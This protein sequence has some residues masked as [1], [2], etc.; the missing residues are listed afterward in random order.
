MGFRISHKLLLLGL[1]S[2]LITAVVLVAVGAWQS[3]R[4]ADSTEKEVLRQNQAALGQS[5]SDVS[6]LV[7]TVGD[8]VQEG[9]DKSMSSASA[10]LSQSGGMRTASGRVSWTATNQVTQEATKV[11]L[12]RIEIGGDWLG[13]NTDLKKATTFVDDAKELSGADVTVFQRMNTAGDLLRV[14]TTVKSAK[15]TRAIGTYIPASADGKANAVAAAILA[16]KTYRGVAVVVGTPYITVYEP[17]KNS[18]GAVIGALFVGVPQADALSTLTTAISETKIQTNG[19]VAVFSTATA[20]RGRIVASNLAD[21]VGQTALDATDADG[22]RY[23]EEIVTKA[24]EL[25]DGSTWQS[26]YQLAGAAGAPAGD[27]TTSVA[28]YAPYQWAVTV[29]GYDADA[30]TAVTVVRDG[31]STMLQ[32]FMI[33]GLLL[34]VAGA[35]LAYL[36]ASRISR[37]MA[38]LTGA[39]QRLANHDLTVRVDDKG[40]DEIGEAG[41]ALNTAVAEL[42]SVMQEVTTA[43]D[44]VAGTAQRVTTTGGEMSAAADTAADRAGA[45]STSAETVSHVV[46]TVAAGAEEMGASISEIS[47]NAQEAAQAGRD[48][49]GLT[50]AAAGVIAELRASTAKITDVVQL[51]ATI[52]EQT[53]LLALNATIEAA[54]AGETGKGFAVVAGEVKELAQETARATEDVTARVAAIN[55]D[56]ARAVQAIDA[57][58][59]RIGQV[60]DYQTA[61][62]AAVEEQAATT[63]EM[64]RNISEAAGGSRDIADGIGTVSGAVQ[65]TRESVATSH[66]AADEL[67]ATAHRLTDLVGRFTVR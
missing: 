56:T 55:A 13:Q 51:I 11:T 50:A 12:P 65:S 22:T 62:A 32:W 6:A 67:T 18:S 30:A 48:G 61:I 4:F 41:I 33:A 47:H 40:S 46:Q 1:G 3:S 14:G 44:E 15:G 7:K 59:E 58:T 52:A 16:G 9:V 24:P 10:F 49:V 45:V 57:I 37:R 26:K 34:A 17:I 64:A 23:V 20:D 5:A 21:L 19:W 35:A 25:T 43:S 38:G 63:A 60:N 39:L 2:V 54:R 53:N 28:F 8:E 66:R 29:G 27:T 36:Q 42:R 31:R